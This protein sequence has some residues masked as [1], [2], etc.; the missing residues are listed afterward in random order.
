MTKDLNF[1]YAWLVI[2]LTTLIGCAGPSALKLDASQGA[3]EPIDKMLLIVRDEA[4]GFGRGE[5]SLK[6]LTRKVK[7]DLVRAGYA[8]SD[9]WDLGLS[10]QE[11][12]ELIEE[13]D[14]SAASDYGHLLAATVYSVRTGSTPAGFSMSFGDS[15]PRAQGFQRAEIVPISCAL[16]NTKSAREEASLRED[17]PAQ[18]AGPLA[19]DIRAV[20]AKLLADLGATRKVAKSE[21][22]GPVE[23]APGVRVEIVPA[24]ESE[25]VATPAPDIP[26]D[27][28]SLE[29]ENAP[30][31][32]SGLNAAPSEAAPAP[33]PSP[34]PVSTP[35][36]KSPVTVKPSTG[37][38]GRKQV[39]IINPG[40]TVI[41]EFGPDRQH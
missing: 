26:Q 3:R 24:E 15:D 25:P 23:P 19:G 34:V 1:K 20:C 27:K 11:I 12:R 4:D 18:G 21:P 22:S 16:V 28:G 7:E 33:E 9:P 17:K 40:N 32:A 31:Q 5:D 6:A 2:F 41:L 35:P 13:K 36:K 39:K 30:P 10:D 29:S 14:S 8:V 37:N 38:A